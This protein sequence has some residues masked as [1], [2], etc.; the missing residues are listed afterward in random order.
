LNWIEKEIS[1]RSP[2]TVNYGISPEFDD[3]RSDSR[4]KE[5]LKR[6]NLPE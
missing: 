1:D 6:L 3:L 4:F 5:M 2:G